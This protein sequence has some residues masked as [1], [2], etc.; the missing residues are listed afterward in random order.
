MAITED[1]QLWGWGVNA[2]G[3][4]GTGDTITQL[5]PAKV[6]MKNGAPFSD[7]TEVSIYM[8]D[9]TSDGSSVVTAIR[10]DGTVWDWGYLRTPFTYLIREGESAIS[11]PQVVNW[12]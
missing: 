6:L 9:N 10:G 4:L 5:V 11:P 3:Q 7:V 1:K 12:P 2:F 8:A